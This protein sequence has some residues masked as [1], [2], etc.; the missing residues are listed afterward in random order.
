MTAPI[1]LDQGDFF[2]VKSPRAVGL[3]IRTIEA[4]WAHDGHADYN[5]TGIILDQQ[6]TTLEALWKVRRQNLF[7]AYAGQKVIIARYIGEKFRPVDQAIARIERE[8]ADHWYPIWRIFMH[9]VPALAKINL[10]GLA[11]C[12]ELA[13]KYAW[14]IGA[15]H[16]QW[17]G[18]NPDT[19]ADEWKH[20]KTYKV[21]FE[22]L[23][24]AGMNRGP[25][26]IIGD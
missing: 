1:Q 22:G 12:S 16:S 14:H 25:L 21:I 6:G 24:R 13:A 3:I 26:P 11:V 7:E 10:S 18:T 17:P 20:W 2:A 9:A 5:H 19:L 15:R 8:Y 4:V 23:L